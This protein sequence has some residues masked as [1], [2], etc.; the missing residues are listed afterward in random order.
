MKLNILYMYPDNLNLYGDN[1]NIE[2]LYYRAKNR[3]INVNINKIG[4][5]D[6]VSGLDFKQ[7]NIIFM[8]GGP[9][10]GQKDVYKDLIKNK[11]PY[12]NDYIQNGGV[13]LFICGSYQ[14]LGNYYKLAN[15]QL[16]NG[17]NIYNL[18]TEQP[19]ND[20]YRCVGNIVCRL[21]KSILDDLYFINNNYIGDLIVGFENHAGRT[22]LT[23]DSQPFG[24]VLKGF[25]NNSYDK[26]E[27][28][29]FNNTIGTYL[30]GPILA[31]NPHLT[32]YLISKSLKIDK[33]NKLNDV[34][35]T[36][37]HN[38]CISI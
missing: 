33:L 20:L 16:L 30:H 25:G 9:D 14:L 5:D 26:L 11:A 13:G 37:A 17:A 36:L 28:I 38:N 22:Y 23:S 4:V 29:H 32:D 1:G 6:K 24:Y 21:S 10:S 35:V 31:K 12:L 8:G 15:N 18:Y 3:G 19:T 7:N 27:G 34:I 2:V